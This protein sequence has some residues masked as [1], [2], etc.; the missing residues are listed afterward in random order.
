MLEG[1]LRGIKDD[2]R[3]APAAREEHLR[4]LDPGQ[5]EMDATSAFN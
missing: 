2:H 4:L 3:S 1:R 5:D